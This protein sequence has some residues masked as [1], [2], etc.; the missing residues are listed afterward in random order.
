MRNPFTELLTPL[1]LLQSFNTTAPGRAHGWL[2]KYRRSRSELRIPKT[3]KLRSKSIPCNY[4]R[5]SSCN[6]CTL[7]RIHG[8]AK[9]KA[10]EEATIAFVVLSN[11]THNMSSLRLHHSCCT[12]SQPTASRILPY[13]KSRSYRV[14]DPLSM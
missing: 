9:L 12:C 8:V 3:R 2:S 14:A 4:G 1:V 5:H 6:G 13:N 10:H 7:A 11:V